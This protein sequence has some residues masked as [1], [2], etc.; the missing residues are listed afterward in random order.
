MHHFHYNYLF[1]L[2]YTAGF[3]SSVGAPVSIGFLDEYGTA[4]SSSADLSQQ[5][6]DV[7][8]PPVIGISRRK[9][10]NGIKIPKQQ[11]NIQDLIMSQHPGYDLL[12]LEDALHVLQVDVVVSQSSILVTL[13][14]ICLLV[15]ICLYLCRLELANYE[16]LDF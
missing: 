16:M 1:F 2:S 13:E 10:I 12:S 14:Q 6:R 8:V 9:G 5:V 11:V 4:P 7:A 15:I 3:L